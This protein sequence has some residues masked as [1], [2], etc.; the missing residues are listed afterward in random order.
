MSSVADLDA[1]PLTTPFGERTGLLVVRLMEINNISLFRLSKGRVGGTIFGAPV[2]LL[3]T[4]GR[5][6]GTRHTKP[7]LA[8]EDAG[9]WVVAGSRGG[10]TRN[11]DWYENLVAFEA[12]GQQGAGGDG[13]ELAPPEVE[14]A[15]GRRLTVRSE[16]LEDAEREQWWS[17]LVE[18]YPKFDT[19]Q[20][21]APHR[22]IPV[23]GL[24]P[25]SH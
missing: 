7:L 3:T 18:V 5:T 10:T 9:R 16:V 13:P 21:R 19:Y 6:T 14:A 8:L 22:T 25:V 15:G 23:V 20:R 2:I 17:R 4:S 12:E 24:S 1:R 11:P